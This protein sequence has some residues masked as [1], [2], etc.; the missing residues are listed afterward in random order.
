MKYTKTTEILIE[1]ERLRITK[2]RQTR[3]RPAPPDASGAAAV[4]PPRLSSETGD[5]IFFRQTFRE[6]LK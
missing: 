2:R 6:H 4:K 5:D 3:T 1:V